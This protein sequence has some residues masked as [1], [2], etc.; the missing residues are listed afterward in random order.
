M[1]GRYI[2]ICIPYVQPV[3]FSGVL[4]TIELCVVY[5]TYT[6]ILILHYM[7]W[8]KQ[9]I[10]VYVT[11]FLLI[12]LAFPYVFN[13]IVNKHFRVKKYTQVSFRSTRYKF[14][15]LYINNA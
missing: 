14:L 10:L 8:I 13:K 5:E 6:S 7:L 4:R 12:Y 11:L 3:T 15:M 1:Y 9:Y 2:C